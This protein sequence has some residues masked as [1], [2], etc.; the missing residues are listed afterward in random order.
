M[1]DKQD[2]Y[3]IEKRGLYYKP[4]GKGYTGIRDEAGLYSLEEV[5]AHFPNMDSPNQDGM[6]FV[7]EKDA[8]EFSKSCAWDVK[9]EHR[10]KVAEA[11][12]ER[13]SSEK[14]AL[15]RAHEDLKAK[16]RK[17][18]DDLRNGRLKEVDSAM[19]L[20]QPMVQAGAVSLEKPAGEK[21]VLCGDHYEGFVREDGEGYTED[22]SK[23]RI[24]DDA[25]GLP[26]VLRGTYFRK[27]S[28]FTGR[29]QAD[30]WVAVQEYDS[31]RFCYLAS[32]GRMTQ[33]LADAA[34]YTDGEK[35][36]VELPYGA[37]F[38]RL[39]EMEER[40]EGEEPVPTTIF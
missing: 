16:T 3:L 7:A 25:D 19:T 27:V 11:R 5:A 28:D 34:R 9:L 31:E 12:A 22:L 21:F 36:M 33:S 24:W 8:P 30:L 18:L 6:T 40:L 1:P 17:L 37:G 32:G 14:E 20:L 4:E 13:I 38:V 29:K 35:N 2:L 39:S 15:E 26:K 10:R 23:A